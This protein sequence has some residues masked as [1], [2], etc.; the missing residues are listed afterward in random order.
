VCNQA[1]DSGND[2]PKLLVMHAHSLAWRDFPPVELRHLLPLL[3]LVTKTCIPPATRMATPATEAS[4]ELF[5]SRLGCIPIIADAGHQ[6][7]NP[8]DFQIMFTSAGRVDSR[9]FPQF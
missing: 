7:P 3:S 2:D 4:S 9:P 1:V 8:V 5:P 6:Q